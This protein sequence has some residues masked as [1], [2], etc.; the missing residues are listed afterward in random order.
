MGRS[1]N[2]GM[3]ALA[4]LRSIARVLVGSQVRF[5]GEWVA[6]F[7]LGAGAGKFSHWLEDV[8]MTR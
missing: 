6:V 5:L 2:V 3:V 1:K 7:F 8:E 4:L